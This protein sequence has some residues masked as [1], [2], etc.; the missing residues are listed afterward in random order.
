MKKSIVL[1]I[2]L[3]VYTW[4]TLITHAQTVNVN[5]SS[6]DTVRTCDTSLFSATFTLPA[7]NHHIS[8]SDSVNLPCAN[9]SCTADQLSVFHVVSGAAGDFAWDTGSHSWVID[10][11]S[12]S[13]TTYTLSY[14]VRL[15][16]S[17]VPGCFDSVISSLI[18]YQKWHD[19]TS[20]IFNVDS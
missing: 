3:V 6:T 16:C 4:C 14:S 17:L 9:P 20:I 7:G 8:I 13:D 5:Y 1:F 2:Q 11:N 10:L 18:F 15:D 19:T 12:I